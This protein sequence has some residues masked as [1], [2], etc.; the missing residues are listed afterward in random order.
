MKSSAQKNDQKGKVYLVGAGPGDPSLF[1]LK[2]ARCLAEAD[3]IIYDHLVCEE[4]LSYARPEAELIYAGK[5]GGEHTLEQ[6]EI[7]S[8]ILSK[9]SRGKVV[10]RLKGG[11]P[12]IFG[13]GGEETEAI[14]KAGVPFEI[15]PGVSS[16]IAAPAYAGIP[17]T[18]RLYASSVAFITGH[19]DAAKERSTINWESLSRAADTLVFLM[20]VANL[21]GIAQRLMSHG[22]SPATPAAA[23]MWGTTS[24]QLTICGTLGDIAIKAR[25][26]GL[27][28]PAIIVIGE[29]VELRKTLKWFELL[30]LHGRTIVVTRAREEASDLALILKRNGAAVIEFP[31]IETVPPNSWAKLDRAINRLSEYSWLIFTSPRGV[32]YF[33]SRL[34]SAGRDVRDLKGVKICA[35]G[36]KTAFELERLSIKVNFVPDEYRAEAVVA[37]LGGQAISGAKILLPRAAKARD[38]IP[39][40]LR[41]LGATVDVVE[42]YKTVRP[43]MDSA[44]ILESFRRGEIDAVTFTSSSTV[45][46]FARALE[47][48][49]V[50]KLLKGVALAAIGPITAQ[51]AERLGLRVDITP[52]D[53]TIEALASALVHYFKAK[54]RASTR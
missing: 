21:E 41:K 33:L 29:V 43:E 44:R 31:T 37:G 30:P 5:C 32:G 16:A 7:N 18:H 1:T 3:V 45:E 51:S 46:N 6:N 22:R 23:I 27:R 52:D 20:G 25:Q 34:A 12:F 49:D 42:A 53:Y 48:A 24:K 47:P 50:A 2:G 40:E 54:G 39:Q 9:A 14:A 26:A 4:L 19:E 15:I 35:I 38:I 10:V 11:D 36:P 28:P 13:R 17:L 8:L